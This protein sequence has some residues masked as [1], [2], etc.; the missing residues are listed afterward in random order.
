MNE[1]EFGIEK[2]FFNAIFNQT[3]VGIVIVDPFDGRILR[4]NDRFCQIVG[5]SNSD[6]ANLSMQ[7]LTHP[8]DVPIDFENLKKQRDGVLKEYKIEK[9]YIHK[10]GH[11]VWVEISV[12][13]LIQSK[14]N[15]VCNVGIIND[16]SAKK[17]QE[18][19]VKNLQDLFA[20]ISF[21]SQAIVRCTNE[22]ELFSEICRI[23]VELGKIKMAWVGIIDPNSQWIIPS[24]SYGS[25]AKEYLENIQITTSADSEYGRGPTGTAI[26]EN[27]PVWNQDFISSPQLKP[28]LERAQKAGWKSS[29]AL[30]IHKK[31]KV[32]GAFT[33]YSDEKN[34]FQESIQSLLVELVANISFALDK[35]DLEN[36][37]KRTEQIL[38]EAKNS[39]E[40]ANRIKSSFLANMSHEIRTPMNAILG[41]SDLGK[42]ELSLDLCHSYMKKINQSASY[43]LGI[44]NDILDFSKMKAG[45]IA[46]EHSPFDLK[47]LLHEIQDIF[48]LKLESKNLKFIIEMDQNI[49]TRYLGDALRLRQI[50][51]NLINN[52]IKFTDAGQIKIS[53]QRTESATTC[54][55][56]KIS[57]CDTGIGINQD[58]LEFLFQPFYQVDSSSQRKYEGTGLGLVITQQLVQLM[59]GEIHCQSMPGIGSCFTFT[60]HL[61]I[62][63]SAHELNQKEE[64]IEY[65]PPANILLVE[66]NPMNQL[67]A[68]VFLKKLG[69]K[70]NIVSDGFEALEFL[71]NHQKDVDLILMDIQMPHLDGYQ[72]TINIRKNLKLNHIPIIAL[73]AHALENERQHCVNVG[74]NDHIAKPFKLHDLSKVLNFWLCQKSKSSDS[75]NQTQNPNQIE[76]I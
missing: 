74:M 39:A 46:L 71:K 31:G 60:I 33:L 63:D 8:E 6:F 38:L 29:A 69:M 26:R 47:Q 67:V 53:I 16:I 59:S 30:P 23:T 15:I 64:V 10:Q 27:K 25:E 43:L 66:D 36:E 4:A 24:Y 11:I 42:D 32:Y 41:F 19:E 57:V 56:L 48:N 75:Q 45:K 9:R 62:D 40:E 50:F 21:C 54:A 65:P 76:R 68:E 35:F 44:I 34:T 12:S 20:G 13:P 22:A 3:S 18:Q 14:N 49:P 72:T 52:A 17:A 73:T 5:Y 51:T 61:D 28:W 2:I 37:R 70:V 7:R 55:Q 58:Q 1:N